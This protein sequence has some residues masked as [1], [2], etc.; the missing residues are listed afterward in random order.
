[1]GIDS[2][3]DPGVD[4]PKPTGRQRTHLKRNLDDIIFRMHTSRHWNR[5]PRDLGDDSTIH[6]PFQRWVE[7]SVL[8]RIRAVLVEE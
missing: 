7:L 8:E 6:R 2:P 5:L 1:M 4:Q 3:G